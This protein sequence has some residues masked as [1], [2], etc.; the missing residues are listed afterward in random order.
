MTS[1]LVVITSQMTSHLD[2][3]HYASF[4]LSYVM[5]VTLLTSLAMLQIGLFIG[6]LTVELILERRHLRFPFDASSILRLCGKMI[7]C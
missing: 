1:V 6:N 2:V 4:R 3:I 5:A 7:H